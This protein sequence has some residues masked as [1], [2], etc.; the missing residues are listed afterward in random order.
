MA[1]EDD[2]A[3]AGAQLLLIALRDRTLRESLREAARLGFRRAIIPSTSRGRPPSVAGLEV[4]AVGSLREAIAAGLSA[5]EAA[6]TRETEPARPVDETAPGVA[7]V[8][9]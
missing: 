5:R 9:G 7:P 8:L 1:E 6:I 4:I 3:I 2:A